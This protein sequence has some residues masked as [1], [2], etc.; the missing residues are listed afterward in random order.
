MSSDRRILDSREYS[1]RVSN[2]T[3]YLCVRHVRLGLAAAEICRYEVLCEFNGY[4]ED[5]NPVEIP[6]EIDGKKVI[7]FEDG[8]LM[9]GE[10]GP[11]DD[12]STYEYT[13]ADLNC[14]MGWITENRF[15]L[16]HVSRATLKKALQGPL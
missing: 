12:D 11:E 15:H 3:Q 8:Y 9:G 10:L 13:L 6:T 14:A 5:G 1:T 16:D 7:R 2:W 4:D